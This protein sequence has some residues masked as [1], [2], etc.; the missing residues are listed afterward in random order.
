MGPLKNHPI[1]LESKL[2]D[3]ERDEL[4]VEISLIELTQSINNANMSSAP[5]ADGI[6]NRFI[7]HYWDYFKSPLL[8]LCNSCYEQNKLPSFFYL[9][10]LNLYRKKGICRK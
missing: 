10:I 3:A 8:K 2:T 5:G 1:V 7:K 9:Q 4:D 6:S